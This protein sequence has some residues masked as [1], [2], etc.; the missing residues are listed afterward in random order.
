M[1]FF[2][3]SSISTLVVAS[4][5]LPRI[6]DN[7][8]P[9]TTSLIASASGTASDNGPISSSQQTGSAEAS[10]TPT[11]ASPS[12]VNTTSTSITSTTGS[13]NPTSG[14][15]PTGAPLSVDDGSLPLPAEITPALSMAGAFL[16]LSGVIYTLIGIKNKTIQI[17]IS[18]AYLIALAI[19]VLLIYIIVPPISDAIQGAYFVAAFVPAA[20]IG[21][22]ALIFKDV[23]EGLGSAAGGFA[24]SM[25]FL[26]LKPGG[27]LTSTA[28]KAIFI[29]CWTAGI[30]ALFFSH[31]I[32][33]YVTIGAT[34]F[35]G[36]T[37]LI[38][39]IDCFSLAGLKE[40]WVYIWGLN[41]KLFP[42][43]QN[44]YPI[45]RGM[46]VEIAGIIIF[47]FFGILSQLKIWKIVQARREKKDL[48]R[49]DEERQRDEEEAEIGMRLEADQALERK[50]WERVYGEKSDKKK[51]SVMSAEIEGEE[52]RSTSVSTREIDG[53]TETNNTNPLPS[54]TS[55]S[56]R[57]SADANRLERQVIVPIA[58]EDVTPGV[59][60]ESQTHSPY[61]TGPASSAATSVSNDEKPERK[62]AKQN[63]SQPAIVPLPFKIPAEENKH[64]D[65][66]RSSDSSLANTK[67]SSEGGSPRERPQSFPR[68][69]SNQHKRLSILT[70]TSLE[71]QADE[72]AGTAQG[73]PFLGNFSFDWESS[74]APVLGDK[75]TSAA[76]ESETQ[77]PED[78]QCEAAPAQE[79][80]DIET[81]GSETGIQLWPM[82]SEKRASVESA[83][84]SKTT[85]QSSSIADRGEEADMDAKEQQSAAESTFTDLKPTARDSELLEEENGESQGLLQ[86]ALSRDKTS[87]VVLQFRTNEWAKHLGSAEKPG[88]DELAF[89]SSTVNEPATIVNEAELLKTP[90]TAQPAPAPIITPEPSSAPALVARVGSSSSTS[91]QKRTSARVS[92]L[93]IQDKGIKHQPDVFRSLSASNH[94]GSKRSSMRSESKRQ[95]Q[96]SPFPPF[97][98][99]RNSLITS[100]IAE[101]TVASFPPHPS[102]N[103][104]DVAA[105]TRPPNR[106]SR[107]SVTDS[108]L[109]V[110][111]YSSQLT[112]R[113]QP[114]IQS[115]EVSA[116]L[117]NEDLPLSKRQSYLRQSSNGNLPATQTAHGPKTKSRAPTTTAHLTQNSLRQQ[118]YPSSQL[119]AQHTIPDHAMRRFSKLNESR[120]SRALETH[121]S[122]PRST[123]SPAPQNSTPNFQGP[124]QGP[125]QVSRYSSQ[126]NGA[127]WGISAQPGVNVGN[128]S[129]NLG[130]G[131]VDSAVYSGRERNRPTSGLSGTEVNNA[132]REVMRKMQAGANKALARDEK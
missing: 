28:S 45:T 25:W 104:E 7:P 79:S 52:K 124:D 51:D 49:S 111:H 85:S 68:Q 99:S 47:T 66:E 16:M 117:S 107:R 67:H 15:S 131:M 50:E 89:P 72:F 83:G 125:S 87:K 8:S 88:P 11:S 36:A 76:N 62:E 70:S 24:L 122:S 69:L 32:R 91:R 18:T 116:A 86:R 37:A 58:S 63:T 5:V 127:S 3:V 92:S 130:P 40:F 100:P 17:F 110:R 114:I 77:L 80:Q 10:S 118:S 43:N 42:P 29:G 82:Q 41:G 113:P 35:A 64:E 38:L 53:T 90:L 54:I 108:S 23:T 46:T 48:E 121:G 34:S 119:Q 31:H 103:S 65:E 2:L 6:A 112:P 73:S 106:L 1:I 75:D 56:R 129:S 26:V 128:S 98:A 39:G 115:S 109:N 95:S 44:T 27:V 57:S 59:S 96:R 123:P 19:T 20:L 78:T 132:H 21:G 13:E 30:Y 22:L 14:A 55:T 102:P 4:H 101:D 93:N 60:D 71:A 126:A 120:R 33:S 94:Q 81:R 105:L 74:D 61:W 12:S 9:D 84:S 97:Q